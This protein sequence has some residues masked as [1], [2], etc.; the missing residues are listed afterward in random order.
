MCI[1]VGDAVRGVLINWLRLRRLLSAAVLSLLRSVRFS[2]YASAL[3]SS[4]HNRAVLRPGLPGSQTRLSA[5]LPARLP[6]Q[7]RLPDR[8]STCCPAGLS[9]DN[10]CNP[11][12]RFNSRSYASNLSVIVF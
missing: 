1:I 11:A 6:G 9:A 10:P 3:L 7:T 12:S 5:C 4:L 8:L 2:V